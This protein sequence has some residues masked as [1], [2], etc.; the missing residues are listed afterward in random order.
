MSQAEAPALPPAGW[1]PDPHDA[2]AQRWWDGARWT[3]H[4]HRAEMPSSTAHAGG[5]PSATARPAPTDEAPV[6]EGVVESSGPGPLSRARA[7]PSFT[8]ELGHLLIAGAVVL[9][10][11]AIVAVI[12]LGSGEGEDQPSPAAEAEALVTRQRED[13]LAKVE[14][15][16]AQV[17]IETYATENGGSYAGA[18]PD[19][20]RAVEP[21]LPSSLEVTRADPG[22]YTLSVAAKNG[23][24]FAMER[25]ADGEL[26]LTCDRPGEGG[27][28]VSGEWGE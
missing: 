21:R 26:F 15:H 18:T 10:A 24:R 6:N 2:D 5:V 8:I 16:G 19:V 11:V 12:L 23:D 3:E 9:I 13:S 17:A 7:G 4:V 22:S 25:E 28:P 27:C 14:A 20:L 1:F